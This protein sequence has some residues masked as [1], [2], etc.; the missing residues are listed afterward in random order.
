MLRPLGASVRCSVNSLLV[1]HGVADMTSHVPTNAGKLLRDYLNMKTFFLAFAL[2]CSLSSTR[3]V[4]ADIAA[5]ALPPPPSVDGKEFET[6]LDAAQKGDLAPMK[7]L[8]DSGLDVNATSKEGGTPL[9]YA[10]AASPQL[11][12]LLIA[13]GANVNWHGEDG[14]DAL[15]MAV[16]ADKVAESEVLLRHG[17]KFDEPDKDGQTPLISAIILGHDKIART[18]LQ[19]GAKVNRAD[20]DGMTPLMLAASMRQTEIVRLLLHAGA[21]VL[22]QDKKGAT[23]LSSTKDWFLVGDLLTKSGQKATAQERASR[24]KDQQILHMLEAAAKRA[25]RKKSSASKGT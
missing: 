20:K 17:A 19:H 3:Y 2:F 11:M 10:V 4:R 8:L 24:A 22:H 21:D 16:I 18:L 14:L 13:R 25:N 12:E 9:M 23:V 1:P 15:G 7:T 6:A 5:T